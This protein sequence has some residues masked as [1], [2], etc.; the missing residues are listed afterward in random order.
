LILIRA[1][2]QSENGSDRKALKGLTTSWGKGVWRFLDAEKAKAK[3]AELSAL[4][5]FVEE[6]ARAMER[7]QK[8]KERLLA[9]GMTGQPFQK[10][11]IGAPDGGIIPGRA[12]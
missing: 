2:D 11:L 8:A 6:R 10:R 3:F 7:R 5:I 12:R 1:F 4:P 9:A